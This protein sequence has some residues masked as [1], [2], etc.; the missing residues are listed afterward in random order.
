M[1]SQDDL[2]PLRRKKDERK[3]HGVWSYL[4]T[5]LCIVEKEFDCMLIKRAHLFTQPPRW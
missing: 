2:Q 4:P 3:R 1:L 5:N